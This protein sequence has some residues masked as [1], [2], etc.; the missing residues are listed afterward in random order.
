MLGHTD[1]AGISPV[2]RR[3]EAVVPVPQYAE[4]YLDN[5]AEIRGI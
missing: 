3:G 5:G 2:Q 1:L 4:D